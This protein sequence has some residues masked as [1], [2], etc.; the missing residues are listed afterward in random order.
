MSKTTSEAV[1][2]TNTKFKEL[3][4]FLSMLGLPYLFLAASYFAF[5][6]DLPWINE[7]AW[8]SDI[9]SKR[10]RLFL[11]EILTLTLVVGTSFYIE[12][13][14]IVK[15]RPKVFL[16]LDT[17]NKIVAAV[18]ILCITG[19]FCLKTILE[20]ESVGIRSTYC[21]FT[22]FL[23]SL[24]FQNARYLISRSLAKLAG[25][26]NNIERKPSTVF[27]SGRN[28]FS[29]I[30]SV[31]VAC[32]IILTPCFSWL[33]TLITEGVSPRTIVFSFGVAI[34]FI[35]L[36]LPFFSQ[37]K[38]NKALTKSFNNLDNQI[39]QKIKNPEITKNIS[40]QIQELIKL[41]ANLK[42]STSISPQEFMICIVQFSTIIIAFIGVLRM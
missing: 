31:S 12:I 16:K 3:I 6:S 20:G 4:L 7:I 15:S 2:L 18:F 42:R 10:L 1:N 34:S 26:I 9:E 40:E 33:P 37:S 24:W 13:P 29:S 14:R 11:L 8:I 27:T 23:I 19:Y 41:R 36:C 5:G 21:L 30:N 32:I 25:I 35:F 17:I 28:F 39:A 38:I 22:F